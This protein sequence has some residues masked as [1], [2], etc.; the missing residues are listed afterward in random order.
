VKLRCVDGT[1]TS[2]INGSND[3]VPHFAYIVK[4]CHV[5]LQFHRSVII[6]RKASN[7]RSFEILVFYS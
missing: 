4:C 1:E 3:S 5:F 7:V 2:F 6:V